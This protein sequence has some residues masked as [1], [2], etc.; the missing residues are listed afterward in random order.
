MKTSDWQGRSAGANRP[1]DSPEGTISAAPD[2][3]ET[4]KGEDFA[5]SSIDEAEGVDEPS[6]AVHEV[7]AH[8]DRVASQLG[9]R[10]VM[11]NIVIPILILLTG[12]GFVKVFGSAEPEARMPDDQ[13]LAGRMRRLPPAEVVPVR[14]FQELGKPLELVVDGVVVP[15]REVQIAGEVSGRIIEKSPLCRAGN[16]VSEGQL[17]VRVDPTDY[18]QEVVRLTDAREQDYEALKE[19]DQ[20]LANAAL[21]LEIAQQDVDLTQREIARLRSLPAGF[22]SEGELDQ[23]QK[24]VLVARQSWTTVNNQMSL[25]RA[26]RGRLEASERL[27]TTQLETAKINLER[28]EIRSP[29]DGMIVR[30]DAELNSF[31]TRG[32]PIVTLE[33]ISKAEVALN[34]RMDQLYWVLDQ[35]TD[36]PKPGQNE[37]E[38][39]EAIRRVGYSLPPT[40]AIVEY[41]ITGL[42]GRTYRWN[43]MLVRY[44]GIGMDTQSRT[45][46]VKVE[47]EAPDQVIVDEGRSPLAATP[48]ALV[49]GMFVRVRLQIQ[50]R[51]P[52][53]VIPAVA[54]RPGN[55]V[56]QFVP[57]PGVLESAAPAGSS[58]S[59][60]AGDAAADQSAGGERLVSEAAAGPAES[61]PVAADTAAPPVPADDVVGRFDPR[62]WLAG[63]VVI[64]QD[65]APIDELRLQEDG[66][67]GSARSDRS[68]RPIR[69]YWVC[70]VGDNSLADGDWL[71]TSPLGEVG[72]EAG[73]TGHAV[74]VSQS[75]MRP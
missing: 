73:E 34:L 49:R 62:E 20:E 16:F 3:S 21:T 59:D 50:P 74:R 18:E 61:P 58:S 48:S 40:P 37:T 17:L 32:S 36:A 8:E 71:I 38:T 27:A 63:R 7:R 26:R 2:S 30:E 43:G 44:D 55:R 54:M 66:E 24:A 31:L 25:L 13:T 23:A 47:V 6:E 60:L 72:M 70:A 5:G 75:E 10:G 68:G 42:A 33:D 41:Q 56:W 19:V 65:V 1:T 35:G 15:H 45:V 64:H 69:R 28:C 12:V 9:T 67:T 46:P 39:L 14:S 29:A 57:D 11:V 4:A 22:V 51:T 53:V 52:L